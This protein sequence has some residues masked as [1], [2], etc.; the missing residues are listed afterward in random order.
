MDSTQITQAKMVELIGADYN[1]SPIKICKK[2][3]SE[4]KIVNGKRKINA[5]IDAVIVSKDGTEHPYMVKN[6][7]RNESE[8]IDFDYI[9]V[10]IHKNLFEIAKEAGVILKRS[11]C[12]IDE[13]GGWYSNGYRYY[14]NEFYCEIN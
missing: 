9:Y 5:T 1:I 6:G 11:K 13:G 12:R 2:Y 4:Y 10:K 14:Y 3:F 8:L 7:N